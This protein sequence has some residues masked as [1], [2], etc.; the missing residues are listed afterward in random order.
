[1]NHFWSKPQAIRVQIFD[2]RP[3]DFGPQKARHTG[4]KGQEKAQDFGARHKSY[5]VVHC[6]QQYLEALAPVAQPG[7]RPAPPGTGRGQPAVDPGSAAP[8]WR[9]ARGCTLIPARRRPPARQELQIC[10]GVAM[11]TAAA[12]GKLREQT[13]PSGP[14]TLKVEDAVWARASARGSWQGQRGRAG[15]DSAEGSS[16]R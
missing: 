9:P 14:A 1:M 12:W 3:F 13:A 11:A 16:R 5:S 8:I 4:A 10:Q 7:S 2:S 15:A 6:S